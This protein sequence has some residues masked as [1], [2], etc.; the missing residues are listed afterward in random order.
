MLFDD[1][2]REQTPYQ[3]ELKKNL[4]SEIFFIVIMSPSLESIKQVKAF[5]RVTEYCDGAAVSSEPQD[6]TEA[7][8]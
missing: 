8:E 3:L 2:Q 5:Y 1:I 4:H 7:V 6:R